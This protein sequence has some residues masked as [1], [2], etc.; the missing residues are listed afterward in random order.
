MKLGI[1]ASGLHDST[2]KLQNVRGHVVLNLIPTVIQLE[3]LPIC[4]LNTLRLT[5]QGQPP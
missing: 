4:A 2:E 1:Y 3:R 5:R